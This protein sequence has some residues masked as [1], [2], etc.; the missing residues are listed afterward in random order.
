M[1]RRV[2]IGV[3]IACLMGGAAYAQDE[4]P[5]D[6]QCAQQLTTAQEVVQDK[7]DANALS[8]ADQEK[9]YELL[10][11]AD[12]LCTEG[13]SDEASAT[14]AAVNQMVAKSPLAFGYGGAG[15]TAFPSARPSL[16]RR[17]SRLS[18]TPPIQPGA[19]ARPRHPRPALP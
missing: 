17:R 19:W 4:E 5:A 8:E 15:G 18:V 13:K 7:V 11:Q 9:V 14:L 6:S 12:A 2:L 16:Q 1:L 10:D 3:A